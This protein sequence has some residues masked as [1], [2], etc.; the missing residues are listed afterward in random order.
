[1]T[2]LITLQVL[3]PDLEHSRL[4]AVSRDPQ[5]LAA[6]RRAVLREYEGHVRSAATEETRRLA[7]EDLAQ[8]RAR[9]FW[10]LGEEARRV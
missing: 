10:V 8:M 1:M 2:A 7:E 4:V 6:F 5:V 9:L 3:D